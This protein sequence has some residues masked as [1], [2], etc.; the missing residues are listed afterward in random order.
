MA[1]RLMSVMAFIGLMGLVGC[2]GNEVVDPEDQQR[3]ISFAGSLQEGTA[4]SRAEQGLEDL[5]DNKTFKVWGYKNTAVSG[6]NYTDYQVVMPSYIVNYGS[7]TAYT[8]TSNT[9][10]WEYVGQGTNQLIKYWDYSAKAYRFFAYALGNGTANAVTVDSSDDTK[11]SFTST[12][13]ATTETN[14]NAAPY[15]TEL[16]FSNDKLADYGKP[17]VLKFM[18]PF[19]RVRFQFRFMDG[20]EADHSDLSL[21]KFCPVAG[22]IPTSGTVTVNYPLKGTD[23]KENWSVAA[24]SSISS[25]T[26]DD[27]WYY[28]MPATSQSDYRLEVAVVTNELQT[29]NVPAQFMQWQPGFQYTYVFK[30]L[31]GG[32]ITLDVIQVAVKDWNEKSTVDRTVYNW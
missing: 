17:V 15:F 25:F 12:V 1:V 24:A 22:T 6:D 3:S 18:K 4:I 20:L 11:V 8:T 14:R 23:T 19:A 30:I 28:V 32:S 31:K 21:I 26:V 10:D 5:L 16:W 29:A 27:Q 13:D 7:N 9:H 2:T